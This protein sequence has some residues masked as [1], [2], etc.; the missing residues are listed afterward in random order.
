MTIGRFCNR[1]VVVAEKT[2]SL[3]EAAQ[4]MRDYHVGALVVVDQEGKQAKPVG[5]L[6]DRDIVVE[7]IAVE[8]PL[9][10][11]TVADVMGAELLS[12]REDDSLWESLQY[13]RGRGVRRMPVTD[14]DG[15]LAGIVSVDD[16]LELFSSELMNLAQLIKHEQQRE[17]QTRQRP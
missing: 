7:V 1:D 6:T 15:F 11:L 12:V 4:R 17:R 9:D 13:M 16:L 10:E 8:A 2:L 5:I 14:N 3:R